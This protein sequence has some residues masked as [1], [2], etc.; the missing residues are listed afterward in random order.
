MT[1][2]ADVL[3]VIEEY[4]PLAERGQIRDDRGRLVPFRKGEV[5]MRQRVYPGDRVAFSRAWY[6]ETR[7]VA[8]VGIVPVALV[9]RP[10]K[11]RQRAAG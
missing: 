5:V 9:P 4:D 3:G 6:P 11:G 1:P 7:R 10:R 8:A 2:G